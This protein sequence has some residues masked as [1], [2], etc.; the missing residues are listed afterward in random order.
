M[1]FRNIV[2]FA[3]PEIKRLNPEMLEAALAQQALPPVGAL[4]MQ[5]RGFV[6]PLA[7]GAF[8]QVQDK[9][10]CFCL[11]GEDRVL[12]APVLQREV[13]AKIAK[14]EQAK[15]HPLGKKARSQIKQETLD[16]L[17]PRAFIKPSRLMAMIDAKAGILAVDTSSLK[18][19]EALVSK[20]REALGS[21]TALPLQTGQAPRSVL[22]QCLL[23]KDLPEQWDLG[24]ECELASEEVLAHLQAGKQVSRLAIVADGVLSTVIGED[25]VLRKFKLLEGAVDRLEHSDT[26]S[27]EQE[28]Q[29]RLAL[30]SAELARFY[31][32]FAKTFAVESKAG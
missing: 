12:P 8:V 30:F 17:M 3:L 4:A 24:E 28:W 6:P 29:A 5:S 7:D 15:G 26:D 14:L 18:A 31:T 10:W 23:G 1:F 27:M 2:L 20:L 21:F 32:Q 13:Q 19:A 16:E 9:A 11:G 22:S 25:L